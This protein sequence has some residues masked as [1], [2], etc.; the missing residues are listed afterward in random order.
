MLQQLVLVTLKPKMSSQG[1]VLRLFVVQLS[2]L[3][4]TFF[5]NFLPGSA[6][7]SCL[8]LPLPPLHVAYCAEMFSVCFYL[9]STSNPR[10]NYKGR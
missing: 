4:R 3:S 10:K 8:L 5:A 1:F 9:Q 2:T 6:R 7:L